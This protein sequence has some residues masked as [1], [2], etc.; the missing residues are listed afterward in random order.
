MAR[1]YVDNNVEFVRCG[2]IFVDMLLPD[3]TRVEKLSPRRLFPTSDGEHYISLL[4]ADGHEHAIVCDISELSQESSA[5]L[6][7]V[8]REY[9]IIPK[10]TAVLDIQM[11]G[12][13]DRWTVMTDR[14]ERTFQIKSRFSDIKSQFDGRILFRDSSDNR[15]EIRDWTKLDRHSR[16]LLNA[17]T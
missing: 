15:Y 17:Y 3:G 8:L 4:D 9:Y 10:I 13:D 2:S 11:K 1:T 6:R 7:D 12:G 5:V 16:I 14:G